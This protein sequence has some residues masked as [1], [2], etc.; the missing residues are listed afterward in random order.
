VAARGKWSGRRPPIETDVQISARLMRNGEYLYAPHSE[1]T[2][3]LTFD[4]RTRAE[5]FVS[6]LD[7]FIDGRE[8]GGGGKR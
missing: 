1:F 3:T 8:F 6:E 4:S 2:R 5:K 7:D